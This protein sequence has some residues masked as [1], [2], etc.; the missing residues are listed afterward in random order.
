MSLCVA[1]TDAVYGIPAEG[2]RVRLF[3]RV[4][5]G[6]WFETG[7]DRTDVN[8][9]VELQLDTSVGR[10]LRLELDM[11]AFYATLGVRPAHPLITLTLNL[12]G[13]RPAPRVRLVVAPLAYVTYLEI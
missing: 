8:G 12:P 5:F 2:V 9:R 13:K 11:D 6:E 1:V 10:A 7:Q 3:D 4:D